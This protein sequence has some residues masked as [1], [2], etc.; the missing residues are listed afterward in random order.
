MRQGDPGDS[1]LL[2]LSGRLTISKDGVEIAEIGQGSVV[3]ELAVFA[4]APRAATVTAAG[5][6]SCSRSQR[7][8]C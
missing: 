7:P 1:L 3:G 2:V 5:T 4:A 8:T 6:A